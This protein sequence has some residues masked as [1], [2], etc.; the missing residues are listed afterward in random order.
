MEGEIV[1]GSYNGMVLQRLTEVL[2]SL[3]RDPRDLMLQRKAQVWWWKQWLT[4]P[5]P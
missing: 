5:D 3:L 1:S 2:I 4:D